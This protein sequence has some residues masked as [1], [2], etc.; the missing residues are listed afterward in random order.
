MTERSSVSRFNRRWVILFIVVCSIGAVALT[1]KRLPVGVRLFQAQNIDEQPYSKRS[2][3]ELRESRQAEGRSESA[4]YSDADLQRMVDLL[5]V[6]DDPHRANFDGLLYA[7]AR[8]LPFLLKALDDPRT[9]TTVF[10]GNDIYGLGAS[11]F[12][13]ICNL[14]WNLRPAGA[15]APLTRYLDHSNPVFR[16]KAAWVLASIGTRECLEPVKRALA[17]KDNEVRES[18]LIGLTQASKGKER[19]EQFLSGVFPALIPLLDNGKYD[20]E[21]PAS[22]MMAVAPAKAALILESPK[23]ISDRN[24]QLPEVLRALDR[25]RVKVPRTILLPLMAKLAPAASKE[26]SDQVAYADALTL[27]ANNPDEHAETEFRTL[28]NSPS[29]IV[30]SAATKGLE[31]LAGINVRDVVVDVYDRRGFDAM[32]QPQQFCFAVELYEDEVDNGGHHQYFYNDDSDLYKV[33]IE[34]LHAIGATPQAAILSDASRAFAPEQ[35]AATEELRR[36]QMEEF[37]PVQDG[38]FKTADQRFYQLEDVPGERLDTLMTLY[39]L[40]HQ[41]DFAVALSLETGISQH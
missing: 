1:W 26:S 11:P 32:T 29:S 18:A 23:Y 30:S 6:Q 37:G 24:P 3:A 9:S 12:E 41:S 39:A 13:R 22:A 36:H 34:G 19:D 28:I 38:I 17:D 5:F 15:A 40:K 21:S 31:T 33:A 2:G 7:G 8:P 20:P 14:L 27:Y 25:P 4:R 16:R 10:S 35:P